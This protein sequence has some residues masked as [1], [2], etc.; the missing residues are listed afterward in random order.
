[1]IVSTLGARIDREGVVQEHLPRRVSENY[2][3]SGLL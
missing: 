1:M 3:E 2:V